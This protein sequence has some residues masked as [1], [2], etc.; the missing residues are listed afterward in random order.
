MTQETNSDKQLKIIAEPNGCGCNTS[1]SCCDGPVVNEEAKTSSYCGTSV[2]NAV[3]TSM[4]ITV[5]IDGQVLEVVQSDKNIVD[6]ANRAKIGIPAACYRA[7]PKK[8]CCHGCVVEVDGEQKYACSTPPANGMN[9][10]V[11]RKDLKAIRKKNLLEYNEGIKSGNFTKCSAT[12]SS[13]C[14]C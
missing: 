1:S 10:A 5:T 13:N 3:S 11:N 7:Q 12:G 6:V 9:I 4:D 8:G 2:T 14:S